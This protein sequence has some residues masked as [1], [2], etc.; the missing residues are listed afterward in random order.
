MAQSSASWLNKVSRFTHCVVSA[1]ICRN[2]PYPRV[3]EASP[4]NFTFLDCERPLMRLH[5][6]LNVLLAP[7]SFAAAVPLFGQ[8]AIMTPTTSIRLL[9]CSANESRRSWTSIKCS[10]ASLFKSC[11]AARLSSTSHFVAAGTVSNR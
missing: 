6:Y 4:S 2:S 5:S 7:A 3:L 1:G 9:R 8:V 10:A 11:Q